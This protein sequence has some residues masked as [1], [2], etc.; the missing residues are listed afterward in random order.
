MIMPEFFFIIRN[1]NEF[2]NRLSQDGT[3]QSGWLAQTVINTGQN[4]VQVLA[5]RVV[6]AFLSL[7]YYPALDFYGSNIPMLTIFASVFFLAGLGIALLRVRKPGMLLLNGYFWAAT[8]A[9]GIFS[10]PP[11]ADFSL[12]YVDCFAPGVRNGCHCNRSTPGIYWSGLEPRQ[13]RLRFYHHLFT[14]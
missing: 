14:P 11:S 7:I 3:F 13:E 2:F 8:L 12:P 1:F 4:P 5:G 9:V 6:H 10:V